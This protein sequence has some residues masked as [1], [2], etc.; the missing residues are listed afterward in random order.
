MRIL[1]EI[2]VADGDRLDL[3]S[4]RAL[5]NAEQFWQIADASNALNPNE[6][7]QPGQVLRVPFPEAGA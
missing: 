4:A 7:E 2:T 6:L 1:G 5:G 3:I